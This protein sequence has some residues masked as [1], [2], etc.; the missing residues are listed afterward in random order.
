MPG[1]Q[2]LCLCIREDRVEQFFRVGCITSPH[3]VH[4]EVKV[5]PTTDDPDRFLDLEK[6]ILRKNGKEE[7]RKISRVRFQK[8][9]II[10]S[11]EGITDRN[12]AELYRQWELYVSRE[13]AI[14]LE[15]NEYFV[16]DLIGMK[17]YQEGDNY[18]GVLRDVLQTGANDVYAVETESYGEV[19]IPAIKACIIK[20]DPAAG[21]MDVHLLPGLIDA[22]GKA[23]KKKGMQK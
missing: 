16:A 1:V 5:Y 2:I 14:P 19:L 3:G 7:I 11:L 18:L 15:E 10:L 12:T 23:G 6:V 9:M 8:N 17:V 21:R 20:V 13:D 22:T 4:G